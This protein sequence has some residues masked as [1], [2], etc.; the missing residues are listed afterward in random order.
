MISYKCKGRSARNVSTELD[1]IFTNNAVKLMNNAVKFNEN[2]PII[3]PYT[4][5]GK[6]F[7]P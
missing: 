5:W 2:A 7:H 1:D 3:L 6:S 4:V